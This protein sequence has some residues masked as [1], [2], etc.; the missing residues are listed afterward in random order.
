MNPQHVPSDITFLER[1]G[2]F[3]LRYD[4]SMTFRPRPVEIYCKHAASIFE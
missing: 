1:R 4:V 3:G 2:F